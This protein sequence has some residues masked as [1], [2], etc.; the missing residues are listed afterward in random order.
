MGASNFY[1]SRLPGGI[2]ATN[3]LASNIVRIAWLMI[4][5]LIFELRGG[6][7]LYRFVRFIAACFATAARVVPNLCNR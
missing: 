1:G 2:G 3:H 5:N 6:L 7:V 4:L